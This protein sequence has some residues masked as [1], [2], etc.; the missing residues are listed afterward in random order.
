MTT[1][2][3][4]SGDFAGV[5]PIFFAVVPDSFMNRDGIGETWLRAQPDAQE[6]SETIDVPLVGDHDRW[7]F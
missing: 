4:Y 2:L 6:W 3:G 7:S 5:D 1:N